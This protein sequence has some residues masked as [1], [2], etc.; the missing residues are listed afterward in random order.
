MKLVIIDQGMCWNE[1]ISIENKSRLSKNSVFIDGKF[2]GRQERKEPA[3]SL[4]RL[5]YVFFA[6]LIISIHISLLADIQTG[7]K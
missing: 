2:L 4:F 1:S 6:N 5:V 3:T 7:A